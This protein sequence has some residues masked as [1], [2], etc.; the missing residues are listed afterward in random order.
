MLASS[1]AF[2][3]QPFQRTEF[4]DYVLHDR[5]G[6]G[7]MAEIF[8]ATSRGIEGFE[9]RLVI[10]RILPTF[11]GDKQFVRMFVEEAKLCV[12]LRHPNIVQVYDLGEIDGQYFIAME[13]V[14]GRDLLKTLAAC[15]KK[16]IG[17]PTDIALFIVME[18]LK[19]LDYA[20]TLKR[21]DGQPLG[22]I[23]R[24]VSPSNVLLSFDG[25]VKMADFGIAKASTRE[26]TETGILKGKFGYMAPEQVTGVQI[27]SRADIFAIGIVLYELL[28]GHRLFAGKNDLAVLERVRDAL[29][30]PSPRHYRPDLAAELEGIVLR[31]LARDPRAR[32]Q[33]ASELHDALF[34]YT[35]RSHAVIGPPQLGRFM[36]GLFLSDPEEIERRIRVFLPVPHAI[37]ELSNTT[38]DSSTAEGPAQKA[39]G[40]P[41]ANGHGR[42]T[43][44]HSAFSR[45]AE[46][47]AF[48]EQTPLLGKHG[49]A[50]PDSDESIALSVLASQVVYIAPDEDWERH[51]SPPPIPPDDSADHSSS[52]RF[53]GDDPLAEETVQ[54]APKG[55]GESL[56]AWE[57]TPS[58]EPEDETKVPAHLLEQETEADPDLVGRENR[59]VGPESAS[60]E[61]RALRR[62]Q[63]ENDPTDLDLS[64]STTKKPGSH[65]KA[66]VIELPDDATT[67]PPLDHVDVGERMGRESSATDTVDHDDEFARNVTEDGAENSDR[68]WRPSEIV[69][70]TLSS[71]SGPTPAV[72]D[73]AS[74]FS[75]LADDAELI[76]SSPND[77]IEPTVRVASGVMP[78]TA[79]S[80]EDLAEA[81]PE[82]LI[83]VE[84]TNE[85]QEGS[86]FIDVGRGF[87][88]RG[89]MLETAEIF[90]EERT[91]TPLPTAE[92]APLPS[93]PPNEIGIGSD[94]RTL[95]VL[96]SDLPTSE[97]SERDL[98]DAELRAKHERLMREDLARP[99]V[100]PIGEPGLEGEDEEEPTEDIH[101][102][103]PRMI[104]LRIP[105]PSDTTTTPGDREEESTDSSATGD[106]SRAGIQSSR[107][108]S[109][110]E[111]SGLS[112]LY[113]SHG[114]MQAVEFFARESTE[115]GAST[116]DFEDPTDGS[117]RSRTPR[118]ESLTPA[119]GAIVSG[120]ACILDQSQSRR[121][122]ITGS[123]RPR[124]VLLPAKDDDESE[125]LARRPRG[126]RSV[127]GQRRRVTARAGLSVVNPKAM[128]D[129]SE[130]TNDERPSPAKVALKEG[131][132]EVTGRGR[133]VDESTGGDSTS[134]PRITAGL[135]SDSGRL[136]SSL[137]NRR[138]SSG[139]SA[140]VSESKVV[141]EAIAEIRRESELSG[142]HEATALGQLAGA[143]ESKANLLE[144]E[145][146]LEI[147]EDDH[148]GKTD[149]QRAMLR[150]EA[151]KRF[152]TNSVVLF[153]E[154]TSV[155]ED[156]FGGPHSDV[157]AVPM[158]TS[159]GRLEDEGASDL[160]G[161]LSML[162][163]RR[164]SFDPEEEVSMPTDS[165][166]R[167]PV[168]EEKAALPRVDRVM[169][170]PSVQMELKEIEAEARLEERAREID[171]SFS[172]PNL[173]ES[174]EQS[175]TGLGSLTGG[176]DE[177][178]SVVSPWDKPASELPEPRDENEDDQ[179]YPEESTASVSD[180]QVMDVQPRH[181]DS[182]PDD[183]LLSAPSTRRPSSGIEI[184]FESMHP[185][186]GSLQ[187]DDDNSTAIEDEPSDPSE[188]SAE[189]SVSSGP[190]PND[191]DDGQL[192][193]EFDDSVQDPVRKIELRLVSDSFDL[194]AVRSDSD[195]RSKDRRISPKPASPAPAARATPQPVP[196]AAPNPALDPTPAQIPPPSAHAKARPVR[197]LNRNREAKSPN[198]QAPN[199]PPPPARTPASPKPALSA[200]APR[201]GPVP[202]VP[203]ASQA[204]PGIAN[205]PRPVGMNR[206]LTVVVLIATVLAVAAAVTLLLERNKPQ[207]V[208][209]PT[210][211]VGPQPAP[212]P[213]RKD[214]R[215]KPPLDG[216]KRLA[217]TPKKED[218]ARREPKTDP[219]EK[220]SRMP[221][222]QE[223]EKAAKDDAA[224]KIA[225]REPVKEKPKEPAKEKPREP[226]RETVKEKP[227]E[228]IK[229]AVKE[230]PRAQ[231]EQKERDEKA[232]KTKRAKGKKQ[233]KKKNARIA[234]REEKPDRERE[235]PRGPA[236]ETASEVKG[237]G[238][239]EV[240]CDEP[241]QVNVAKTV[242]SDVTKQKIKL[243]P[244]S[245]QVFI[246]R[247]PN[248]RLIRIV[249]VV[250][251]ASVRVSCE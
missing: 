11:S 73:D 107:L 115:T 76:E 212:D 69:E 88:S 197:E 138:T 116:D 49:S 156:S 132:G 176:R 77:E 157:H 44:V 161:A 201:P 236:K 20:H 13:Y 55:G 232:T 60:A 80:F 50:L 194:E 37:G 65:P 91:E 28:T 163:D 83:E 241:S 148:E 72:L 67:R 58:P 90:E 81:S 97:V 147:E 109:F 135:L 206:F 174:R 89:K 230:G 181:G 126:S 205:V 96:E 52:E 42:S 101:R 3:V 170:A 131:T 240:T 186:D 86:P 204:Y 141:D 209:I 104:P 41:H 151:R 38:Q 125:P 12:A 71:D 160:F 120:E 225:V 22:I 8:L 24:D 175:K 173:D 184:E 112:H 5:I 124:P 106:T 59:K 235:R 33:R 190:T 234:A 127:P 244:G 17:F 103:P 188:R 185:P 237:T 10:K 219:A 140:A 68:S 54:P 179:L 227:K 183:D 159:A 164:T 119:D 187:L 246:T 15:G 62:A 39:N 199:L 248:K 121:R 129:E 46:S 34:E 27:D 231:K 215:A 92:P 113:D 167:R 192:L 16:R 57:R 182:P 202:M 150:R 158:I 203:S 30:E 142:R 242:Y 84:P 123:K 95:E 168:L 137:P 238:I 198:G 117:D 35:F 172:L 105:D 166:K 36:Q 136:A 66:T 195:R 162:D 145:Q 85:D 133:L 87:S 222:R 247:P 200:G 193:E 249:N 114:D 29:I 63:E 152:M 218:A 32:F 7:G 250:E 144:P 134:R 25:D 154:D 213:G 211:A 74:P 94:Y 177:E 108:S 82:D 233:A 79:Q 130:A 26:K 224:E 98:V 111:P 221:T 191:P 4:G 155:D 146:C 243:A 169:I 208:K 6:A 189:F 64:D 102:L 165:S 23:H 51:P 93:D 14:D 110:E 128:F 70:R 75:L 56:T 43:L 196:K 214:D 178:P 19:G 40:H 100:L 220:V 207:P 228:P 229:E 1:L 251:G 239:M 2:P 122:P 78:A 245:Y 217:E 171:D 153:A 180:G 223:A 31:A 210:R 226:V 118:L 139:I 48:D 53:T 143:M 99:Q 47:G 61:V 21:P 45:A 149:L 18:V 216:A 9:K